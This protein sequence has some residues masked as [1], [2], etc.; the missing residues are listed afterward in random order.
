MWVV[1]DTRESVGAANNITTHRTSTCGSILHVRCSCLQFP[2][3]HSSLSADAF[4]QSGGAILKASGGVFGGVLLVEG[5]RN[6]SFSRLNSSVSRS[7]SSCNTTKTLLTRWVNV[8]VLS[9]WPDGVRE[10]RRT[11]TWAEGRFNLRPSTPLPSPLWPPPLYNFY[12]RPVNI[13][14]LKKN[15]AFETIGEDGLLLTEASGYLAD[16]LKVVTTRLNMTALLSRTKGSGVLTSNGTWNGLMGKMVHGEGDIGALDFTPNLSRQEYIDFTYPIGLDPVVIISSAPHI[17]TKPFLLLQI[18]SNKVWACLWATVVVGGAL[19]GVMVKVESWI[20]PSLSQSP[21][22]NIPTVF[23]LFIYQN[24]GRVPPGSGGRV[25]MSVLL[26]VSLL[27]GSIYSGSI[28]TFLV[29]PIKSLPI[30]SIEDLLSSDVTI[31]ARSKTNIASHVINKPGG[32]LYSARDRIQLLSSAQ[33]STSDFHHKLTAGTH[34]VVDVHSSAMGRAN[35][36][37]KPR[38]GC[39]IHLAREPIQVNLDAIGI[40]RNSGILTQIDRVL[41]SL[42]FFGILQH[43]KGLY[44]MPLCIVNR[45]NSGPQPLNV[46][47]IQGPALILGVGLTVAMCV[48]IMEVLLYRLP[49][50]VTHRLLPS[51]TTYH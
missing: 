45:E 37:T 26:M 17:I 18:F 21:T 27:V 22:P 10:V 49:I 38:E 14:Y 13:G 15:G 6:S 2:A 44:Y 39:K 32:A 41:K 23:K 25:W 16:I 46:V 31:T 7:N 48:F 11:A 4:V 42:K 5:G 20:S 51:T 24:V 33:L 36:Y 30:N 1:S 40:R 43:I 29:L 12:G 35:M 47:Q 28:T 34:A 8:G 50:Q 9:T 3:S 19:L